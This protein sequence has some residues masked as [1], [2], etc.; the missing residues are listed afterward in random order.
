MGTVWSSVSST[1]S[2]LKGLLRELEETGDRFNRVIKR[3][4]SPALPPA[5]ST[6]SSWQC[7]PLFPDLVD[8]QSPSL[9][10]SADIV[11]IGSGMSGASLAYTIL[12]ECETMGVS[13]SVVM[14]E[15][16]QICSGA[17]GRNG[18]H[19]KCVPYDDYPRWKSRFGVAHARQLLQFQLLH[20]PVLSK[21]AT[22]EGLTD[23]DVREV[24]T[25]DVFLEA[26]AWAKAKAM[27]K[28]LQEDVPD[29]AAGIKLWESAEAREKFHVGADC[30]GVMT[31]SAGALWP[32]RFVTALYH[33]LLARHPQN[34][35]I[36][37]NTMVESIQVSGEDDKCP[38]LVKTSR[39]DIA[40]THVIHATD[41][42]AST[43]IPGLKGKLFPIRG[44][45]TAQRPGD[46]F[47]DFGGSRSW[48]L[49]RNS[50][51]EYIT[52]HPHNEANPLTDVI[53]AGGGIDLSEEQGMDE[54][55]VWG[56]DHTSVSISAYLGGILPVAFGS[57]NWGAD[58]SPARLIRGWTGCMGF[59]LD[60]LPYVGRLDPILTGRKLVS[61][62]LGNSKAPTPCE[63]I[64]AGFN[65]EGMVSTWLAGVAVGLM[66]LGREKENNKNTHGRPDGKVL[67]WLPELLLCAKERIRKSNIHDFAN[68]VTS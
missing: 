53:M 32:Y 13:K 7:D 16:R 28:E 26:R 45:M 51:F 5:K 62:N 39:G 9:G 18:G 25:V 23:A 35:S 20:L 47:P 8:V 63:W 65:G 17:T 19:V 58:S 57:E 27:F 52:Q 15:G 11:I 30:V 55:G 12:T 10:A 34:F 37:T 29:V 22:A 59:T 41:A 43:L 31:Y 48:G 2:A 67:D 4:S 36:E 46:A 64:T 6:V 1:Y 21:L 66:V 14:L 49:I 50:G 56:D 60:L 68:W 38:F 24:E 44:H 3:I 54:V 42:F 61:T 33:L 40:A